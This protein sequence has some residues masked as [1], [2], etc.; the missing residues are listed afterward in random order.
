M[1]VA[2][3]RPSTGWPVRSTT[4]ALGVGVLALAGW[5]GWNGYRSGVLWREAVAAAEVRAWDRVEAALALHAWYRPN[6]PVAIPLRVEA[7]LQRGDREAAV[8][9]LGSVPESSSLAESA[10]LGRGRILKELYRPAEAIDELRACLRLNPRRLEA[11]RELII[12]LGILRRAREQEEQL[13]ALHDRGGAAVEALRILAQS[14]V[15]IPPGALAKN[16]DEGSVLRRCLETRPDD[17]YLPAPL[18][19]FLRNRGQVAEARALLQPWLRTSRINSET[20]LEDLACLLDEGD[21]AS[22]RPWFEP[23][24]ESLGSSSRYWLL[25]GDWFRM[26]DRHDE[27]L[28]SYREA[29]QRDPRSPE[30]RYRLAHALRALRMVREADEVLTDHQRLQ[31]LSLLAA[32]LSETTS[33]PN[34]LAQAARLCHQLGR[35]REAR[36]WYAAVLRVNPSD[37]E[38]RGFRA[39]PPPRGGPDGQALAG[40]GKGDRRP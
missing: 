32:D 31:Q 34:R 8:R 28:K 7:A 14:T 3:V 39:E 16:A 37:A 24:E 38:A 4:L 15:T 33:D 9:I 12:I 27:A 23:P 29:V 2:S 10:H 6:D 17:P 22:A 36:A 19:Y 5:L 18:A 13:W 25:R 26:Q 30:A 35:D 11:H 21:F 40:S 1:A 20:R